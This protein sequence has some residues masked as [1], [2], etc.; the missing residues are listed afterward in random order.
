MG[1]LGLF[2][3]SLAVNDLAHPVE[4]PGRAGVT[5]LG[6]FGVDSADVQFELSRNDSNITAAARMN[7][8]TKSWHVRGA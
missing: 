7:R 4:P 2:G 1:E 6:F 3:V 5:T 8:P